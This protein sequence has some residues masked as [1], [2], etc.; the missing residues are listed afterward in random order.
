MS[1]EGAP[2]RTA[3]LGRC[4]G[5]IGVAGAGEASDGRRGVHVGVDVVGP[6]AGGEGGEDGP[7][8]GG[9]DG[10]EFWE[11]GVLCELEVNVCDGAA[12]G[13]EYMALVISLLVCEVFVFVFLLVMVSLAFPTDWVWV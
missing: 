6:G 12:F 8:G 13:K 7:P 4:D 2:A 9:P 10:G 3:G 1:G 5:M 11:L